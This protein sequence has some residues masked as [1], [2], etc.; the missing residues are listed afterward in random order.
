MNTTI[1]EM[2][3][4]DNEVNS[5]SNLVTA[6]PARFKYVVTNDYSIYVT[7]RVLVLAIP[8]IFVIGMLG[9]IFSLI[10][11]GKKSNQRSSCSI[12]LMVL[13]LSDC[14]V[15]LLN[16]YGWVLSDIIG[17]LNYAKMQ[18]QWDCILTT[19]LLYSSSMNGMLNIIA[20]TFDRWIAVCYPLKA[21]A[22]CTRH[23]AKVTAF[24]LAIVCLVF[25]ISHIFTTKKSFGICTGYA[26]GGLFSAVH[27][28][29][30]IAVYAVVPFI[31]L[32]VMNVMIIKSIRTSF[33]FQGTSSFKGKIVSSVNSTKYHDRQLTVMLLTVS[34]VFLLLTLP[35][36]CR[37]VAAKIWNYKASQRDYEIYLIVH[38]LTNRLLLLNSA[39]NFFLYC[40]GGSRFRK[41]LIGLIMCCCPKYRHDHPTHAAT[42]STVSENVSRSEVV[43]TCVLEDLAEVKW[44]TSHNDEHV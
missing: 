44:P 28:W 33:V 10:I 11:M 20:M 19:Y 1:D 29:L 37:L 41:D 42:Q 4:L 8:V 24:V 6:P 9:N 16:F 30:S 39:I 36:Y 26:I 32:M 38:L 21:S 15:I 34:F 17:F 5:T 14:I 43:S 31:L 7:L 13:A 40:L 35:Q 25:N 12:Y 3:E 2:S 22:V 18:F 23:R 27:S